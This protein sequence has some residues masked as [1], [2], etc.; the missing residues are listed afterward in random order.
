MTAVFGTPLA[1]VLLAVE[2]LLF[3]LRPRSLLPV[4]LACSVAAFLRPLWAVGGP[5]FPM[6]TDK[7]ELVELASC[8]LAGLASGGLSALMT[9]GLYRMEDL[10]GRLPIH[11][12]WW[13]ALGGLVVGHRWLSSSRVRS[14]WATTSSGICSP[15]ILR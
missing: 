5:L 3:E 1:A 7:P 11:W 13:P 4:A 14:A 6:E 2:L 9:A 15:T 10:F 8:L 12:M